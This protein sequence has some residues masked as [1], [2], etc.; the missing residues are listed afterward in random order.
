MLCKQQLCVRPVSCSHDYCL[1]YVLTMDM[2]SSDEL[3][4]RLDQYER[5]VH[6]LAKLQK[7]LAL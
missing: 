3:V 2:P 6:W 5:A 1:T 4:R 7:F